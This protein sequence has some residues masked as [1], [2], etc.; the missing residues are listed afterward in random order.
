MPYRIKD[1]FL[2]TGDS[3][4]VGQH[5]TA[6]IHVPVVEAITSDELLLSVKTRLASGDIIT[7]FYHGSAIGEDPREQRLQEA[8]T[9]RVVEIGDR[10]VEFQHIGEIERY[11]PREVLKAEV[12]KTA[13][14]ELKIEKRLAGGYAVR[15]AETDHDHEWF[16]T[17]A[18]AEAY[19]AREGAQK[20]PETVIEQEAAETAPA[21]P[22]APD[23]APMSVKRGKG[24]YLVLDASGATLESFKTKKDAE[25]YVEDYG[26]PMEAEAA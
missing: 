25:K 8:A 3:M 2:Y 5:H 20:A 21:V 26:A 16:G 4:Q 22:E 15:D 9:I 17:L 18:E 7:L 10:F 12:V 11:Q 14:R 13:K 23:A 19:V 6:S 24:E 1:Q